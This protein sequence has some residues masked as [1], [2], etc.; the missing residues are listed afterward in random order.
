MRRK[1]NASPSSS[2]SGV[3]LA[4]ASTST[5]ACTVA[6]AAGITVTSLTTIDARIPGR[7]QQQ[8]V[9]V[10]QRVRMPQRH[11]GAGPE[12]R[13]QRTRKRLPRQ[14]GMHLGG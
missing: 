10:R 12:R 8:G 3:P 6:A 5:L 1:V 13:F 11:L 2:A 4:R 7:H 14:R 9:G